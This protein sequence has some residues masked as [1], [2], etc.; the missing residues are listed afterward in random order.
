MK[1]LLMACGVAAVALGIASCSGSSTGAPT[2]YEDSLSYYMGKTQGAYFAQNI[3]T[4]PEPDRAKFDKE[5]FLRGLKTVLEADTA[6]IGYLYG[7]S[8]GMN[9]GQ[10]LAMMDRSGVPVNRKMLYAQFA[11][12]FKKDSVSQEEME[13]LNVTL[14]ELM[15]AAH[16][17]ML[18]KQQ[19]DQQEAMKKQ[20]AEAEKNTAAGKEFVEK[21]K[22]AD[23]TIQTTESGLS[24]KV[25]KQGEGAK[26]GENDVAK[27]IYTGKL[28]D[29]TEFDSSKG[30][31]VSFRPTQVVPGFGEALKM[32]NKGSKYTIYIPGQL[33]Y[34]QNGT[35]DGKIPP[36]ATLVFELEVVDI[37]PAGK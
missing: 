13:K 28:I 14:N 7:L 32:M 3:V 33:A 31:A 20:Q 16:E 27:V 36:M 9:L 8:V 35:P 17:K 12:S 30:E 4:L 26:V 21:A 22:A 15:S 34:G 5:S 19:Q 23:N 37:E 6:E 1:K 2:T 18:A 10:Q 24:Y 11:E 25:E 29:G